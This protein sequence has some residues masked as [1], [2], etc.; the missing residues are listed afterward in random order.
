MIKL[1]KTIVKTFAN[2]NFV[3]CFLALKELNNTHEYM[4]ALNKYL[5]EKETATFILHRF[6]MKHFF[7]CDKET[8]FW[9]AY[10]TPESI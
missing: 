10:A 9:K 4:P 6:P 7:S 3:V 8:T 1:D 5:S 2:V